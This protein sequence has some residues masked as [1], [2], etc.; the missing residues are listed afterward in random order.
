MRPG[1]RRHAKR[2]AERG[3]SS[4]MGMFVAD[5]VPDNPG[6]WFFRT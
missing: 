4:R 5:M 1:V 6:A 2:L 3:P